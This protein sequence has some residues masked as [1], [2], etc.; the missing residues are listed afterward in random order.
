MDLR[1]HRGAHNNRMVRF[2]FE[3]R[4]SSISLVFLVLLERAVV[5]ITTQLIPRYTWDRRFLAI[6]TRS[7]AILFVVQI[8]SGSTRLVVQIRNFQKVNSILYEG[9]E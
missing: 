6:T 4:I 3:A 5:T 1:E 9:N 8:K 7:C 2:I